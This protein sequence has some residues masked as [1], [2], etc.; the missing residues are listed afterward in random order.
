MKIGVVIP[1]FYPATVYGGPLHSSLA[2]CQSLARLG[3]EVFVFTTNAN[4]KSH[5]DVPIREMVEL[6]PGLKVKYYHDTIPTRLSLMMIPGLW[7]DLKSVD[8]VY[9]QAI[10]SVPTPLS[11]LYSTLQGKTV[12]VT[13]RGALGPDCLAHGPSSYKS[14]WLR[15]L[16]TPFLS[17][18][19]WQA[20]SD[21]EKEEILSVYP[22]TRTEVI[23]NGIHAK[24]YQELG[25][26]DRMEYLQSFAANELNPQEPVFISLG[27][28]HPIKGLDLL[29]EAF[30]Q[31]FRE[32]AEGYLIIAGN[33]DGML[34]SL[35]HQCKK[36]QIED[37]VFFPGP[38]HGP[39]KIQFLAGGDLFIL[40]SHTENF[41]LVYAE[42]LASGTP[43]IASK[44]TPWSELHE[45]NCGRWINNTP[46]EITR[47]MVD[48]VENEDLEKMGQN[49]R[50]FV[51]AR[52]D[53]M[54][55]AEHMSKL[56]EEHK[57]Q[58]TDK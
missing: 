5:T 26:L 27:R 49:G 29:V 22:G 13:P 50:D 58:N 30:S 39:Q 40:P 53:W 25:K 51:L 31:Y 44:N 9:T 17:R 7:S 20:T 42:A 8:V 33:N 3:H 16:I 32:K 4:G 2:M 10:F 46:A 34:E 28:L 45:F 6:E 18:V 23:P 48:L 14:L 1:S 57:L 11:L 55:L 37:R 19:A 54:S 21:K 41:G 56:L 47:N 43:V 24:D 52:F 12:V 15:F 36:L 35:K 38:L